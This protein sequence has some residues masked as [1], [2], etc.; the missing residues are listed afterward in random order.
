MKKYRDP[1]I[2]IG[3]H[4]SG[5]SMLTRKLE[6]LGL[7][8]GKEKD[9][10]DEALFFRK[11]NEWLLN[12]AGASWNNPDKFKYVDKAFKKEIIPVVREYLLSS[13]RKTYFKEKQ[14]KGFENIN[15]L[16][17]W[18]DPRNTF[19]IELWKEIFPNMKVIHIYRNPIDVAQSLKFRE[20][21]IRQKTFVKFDNKEKLKLKLRPNLF[22]NKKYYHS[23]IEFQNIFEGIELWKKYTTKALS[24]SENFSDNIVHIKYEDILDNPNQII[25]DL[26]NFI[27]YDSKIE[28]L[29]DIY[30]GF[31]KSRKYAFLNSPELVDVYNKVKNDKLINQLGYSDL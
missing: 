14:V 18:K 24:L 21:K 26:I 15:F 13:E 12:Q 4:R 8:L 23:T 7:F 19:T 6:D 3:M 16:W 10:N 31:D 1:I 9:E 28:S 22:F 17:G 30:K 25:D 20:E 29:E 27:N 5:T 2:I 11:I